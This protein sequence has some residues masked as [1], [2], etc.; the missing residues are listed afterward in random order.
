MEQSS[1]LIGIRG[2]VTYGDQRRLADWFDGQASADALHGPGELP[3]FVIAD[4][5]PKPRAAFRNQAGIPHHRP[6]D[7][8]VVQ[9]I[10][11]RVQLFLAYNLAFEV[12]LARRG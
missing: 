6:Q 11:F 10:H 4:Q 9:Q 3:F 1:R 7:F 12:R 2:F 8:T 5:V